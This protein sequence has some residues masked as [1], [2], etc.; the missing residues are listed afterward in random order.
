VAWL[1]LPLAASAEDVVRLATAEDSRSVRGEILDYTGEAITIAGSTGQPRRYPAASVMEIQSA[2]NEAHQAGRD[3]LASHDYSTAARHLADANRA[4]PRVWVRRLILTDLMRCHAAI[5]QVEQAGDLLLAIVASDPTTPAIATAPLAW[6]PTTAVSQAKAEAWLAGGDQPAAVL[7]G[8]S[9]LQSTSSAA[10]ARAALAKLLNHSDARLVALAEAQMWRAEVVRATP[11]DAARWARRVEQMPESVRAGPYFVLAQAFA[12]LGLADEA[13]LAYLR[14][15][16]LFADRRE[17]AAR[18][19]VAAARL[20]R[21]AGHQDET[22]L[23]AAEVVTSFSDTRLA[24]EAQDLLQEAQR[25][26]P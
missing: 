13:A 26:G 17:L 23:L 15:P 18:S 2:W 11:A 3:A 16:V 14:V 7:L 9:H 8:A 4:E 21:R 5:G 19:L 12:R 1:V 22:T 6:F 24:A 20:A 10:L 25:T